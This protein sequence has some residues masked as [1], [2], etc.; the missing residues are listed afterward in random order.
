M[1]RP[2]VVVV[3]LDC[4]TGLQASR[5][6]T[7]RGVEVI[8]V[9]SDPRHPCART[10]SCQRVIRADA[11]PT[12]VVTALLSLAETLDDRPVLLPCTDLAVLG[13]ARHQAELSG[14]YRMAPCSPEVIELLLDKG[15]FARFAQAN[16]LPTP[17][18]HV[19]RSQGDAAAA[20]GEIGYPCVLKPSVKVSEWI[21]NVSAKALVADS[22]D[23]LLRLYD[24]HA[25]R[26]EG[27]VVQEWIEGDDTDHYTCDCYVSATGEPLVTFCSRKLRQWPPLVGQGCL[28]V[29][30]RN[31]V[32]R[33]EAIRVLRA[34]GH[35]GLGYLEM[36]RDARSGRHLIIEANVGRPTGRSAAAERAGVELLMTMYCD[37]VGAPLPA[38]R[39]QRFRGTKWIHVR[40]DVQACTRL[41]IG[42]RARLRDIL[43]SWRGPFAFALFSARDPVPFFAD[44]SH[45]FRKA[46]GS[47]R[48]PEGPA[49]DPAGRS[50]A[51]PP[52]DHA[53][54]G[55]SAPREPRGFPPGP[56][57]AALADFDLH[58]VVRIRTVDAGP[59]E[60]VAVARDVGVPEGAADGAPDIVVC[61][62]DAL[63]PTRLRLMED[64]VA[65]WGDDGVYFLD[66][67][68]RPVAHLR[69]GER[70][71][72]ALM[73]CRRG[74]RRVP[75]LAAVAHL[76]VLSH[77]WVPLRAMAWSF[78]GTCVLASRGDRG[79]EAGAPRSS[80]DPGAELLGEAPVLLSKDGRRIVGFLDTV[81]G[82]AE[83]RP[84]AEP[85]PGCGRAGAGARPDVLILLER[86]SGR[87]F[88]AEPIDGE[89]LAGHLAAAVKARLMPALHAHVFSEIVLGDR[90]WSGALRAPV[91]AADTLRSATGGKPAYRVRHPYPC[92]LEWLQE[93]VAELAPAGRPL[94]DGVASRGDGKR[95]TPRA[96]GQS[97]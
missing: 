55:E 17:R 76:A 95:I 20:A 88:E 53:P 18:T 58:G 56:P 73:V 21:Q 60:L 82:P 8:G 89:T 59:G 86:R 52:R 65:A 42:R 62:V 63:S 64:G 5:V 75:C 15:R 61:F 38:E 66:H 77:G 14:A 19:V 85:G 43:R 29:E 30:H 81:L 22:R 71:G 32:V 92:P 33:D 12:S 91:V 45:A 36:K 51:G 28:S 27:F 1:T 2:P 54:G 72:Q 34:A 46:L 25:S 49:P 41:L 26:A 57:R 94:R 97:G 37:L 83:P 9:A 13:A 74:V 50:L 3:G 7:A 48:A 4:P 68:G 87:S 90:G 78:E 40:R 24:E 23:A 47:R 11:D 10:R 96:R 70:W 39:T 80:R 79:G 31:D 67:A 6:F 93:V 44:L 69:R 84:G 16:G 35:H